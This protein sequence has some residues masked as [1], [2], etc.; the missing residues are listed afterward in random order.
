M[1]R[2]GYAIGFA[3]IWMTACVGEL[4]QRDESR[5][6][7]DS[8]ALLMT[9]APNVKACYDGALKTDPKAAGL[10]VVHFKV[11]PETGLVVEPRLD[12]QKTTAPATLG[13]CVMQ[14]VDGLKLDPADSNEGLATFTWLFK[15]RG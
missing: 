3:T 8:R 7:E 4:A 12:D 15:P 1:M 6:R 11:Q 13:R 2:R 10:V 14:A 5:Y 9:K